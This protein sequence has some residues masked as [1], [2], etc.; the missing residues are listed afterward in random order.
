MLKG[1][2][3]AEA[4]A[5]QST[6]RTYR[7]IAT[8]RVEGLFLG[9]PRTALTDRFAIGKRPNRPRGL[10]DVRSAHGSPIEENRCIVPRD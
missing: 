4:K 9:E 1:E 6:I 8:Y 3:E 7:F 5:S 2:G 10:F